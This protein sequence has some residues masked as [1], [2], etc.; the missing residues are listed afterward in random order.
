MVKEDYETLIMGK[1]AD[2][3]LYLRQYIS[4]MD[5][6]REGGC[7]TV[8]LTGNAEPQQNYEFLKLF[9][10]INKMMDKPFRVI[11]MQTTGVLLDADYLRFLR[12]HVG[13]TTISLSLSA[14]HDIMNM[15]YNGTKPQLRV[16]IDELCE[17]IKSFGF[18]L[19]LSLNL[20][21]YYDGK[22][23]EDI[24]WKCKSLGADQITFRMM[25]GSG[26]NT[27]KDMWIKEHTAGN[28]IIM[29]IND[30]IIEH[31]T[32]LELLPS[33]AQKYSIKEMSTIMDTDCMS[34]ESNNVFRY[35]I[36]RPDCK[37]YSKWDDKGSLIF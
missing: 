20:T 10:I 30:Y 15:N 24:I 8:M 28:W 37:L 31:G 21:D 16:D 32:K 12:N 25:Y 22:D 27:I 9:G 35:L 33:G 29:Q 13:V 19:R 11:E 2:F 18:N 7:D 6:V 17:L 4:R 34:K 26:L 23:P 3:D 5:F 36:L 14:L 1:H